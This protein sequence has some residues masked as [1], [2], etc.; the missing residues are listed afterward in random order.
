MGRLSGRLH[1]GTEATMRHG[2]TQGGWLLL[3]LI[4]A[5]FGWLGRL[6]YAIT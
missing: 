3:G 1:Q 5:S 6:A 2:S 4:V